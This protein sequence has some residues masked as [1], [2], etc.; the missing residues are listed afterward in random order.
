MLLY[1]KRNTAV[2]MMRFIKKALQ[3]YC[4]ALKGKQGSLMVSFR[5]RLPVF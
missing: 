1:K 2:M 3:Y 4:K 5:C